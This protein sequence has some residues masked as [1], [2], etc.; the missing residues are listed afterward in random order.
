MKYFI[1]LENYWN[2]ID[3]DKSK[4]LP[5]GSGAI[6]MNNNENIACIYGGSDYKNNSKLIFDVICGIC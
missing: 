5:V 1:E 6:C 2:K 4:F 3:I